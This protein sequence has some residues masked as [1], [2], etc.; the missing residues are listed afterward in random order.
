MNG[1]ALQT[2]I[3]FPGTRSAPDIAFT[4]ETIL[5]AWTRKGM[6][7]IIPFYGIARELLF[8]AYDMDLS[9]I[10]T[11]VISGPNRI[12]ASYWFT[13]LRVA[14]VLFKLLQTQ[15]WAQMWVKN[16]TGMERLEVKAVVGH[17]C[18]GLLAKGIALANGWVGLA[19]DSSQFVD[20]PVSIFDQ[21]GSGDSQQPGNA[22][23]VRWG[24]TKD[25]YSGTS[26]QVFP[27][28]TSVKSEPHLMP[29]FS[30]WFRTRM[31]EETF[32]NAA[33]GCSTTSRFDRL[34]EVF[35]GSAKRF[36]NMFDGWNRSRAS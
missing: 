32:C 9:E 2:V 27:E 16:A 15:P 29:A 34:C 20:S 4:I 13:A 31:T 22:S 33:A 5:P 24:S 21:W 25:F 6:M 12:S 35:L 36:N 7:L 18:Y 1:L 17:G 26:L 23:S 14:H 30:G 28:D 10:I 3:A 11:L 19:F 8:R